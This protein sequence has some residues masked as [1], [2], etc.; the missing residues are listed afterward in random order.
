[1]LPVWKNTKL[2]QSMA[3]WRRLY[4]FLRAKFFL[5]LLLLV[6]TK[7]LTRSLT[8]QDMARR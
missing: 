7:A 2:D 5:L 4:P 8:G 6:S 3:L 1:M